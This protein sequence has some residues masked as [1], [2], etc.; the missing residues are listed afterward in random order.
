MNY[1]TIKNC[2]IKAT[3]TPIKIDEKGTTKQTFAFEGV[4]NL[5]KT[6]DELSLSQYA[7]LK[8]AN[9][10]TYYGT[11]QSMVEKAE[12]DQTVQLL[13]DIT[14]DA[15]G[16]EMAT[17]DG[18]P[19]FVHVEGKAITVDLNGKTIA[20]DVDADDVSNFVIGVFSTD[21]GGELTLVDNSAERTGTVELDAAEGK[22]YSLLCNYE[23]GCKITI[24]GGTY[25]ANKVRDCLVYSGGKT[26]A[27]V[28]VNG[29]NF[30]LG[31]V[32]A[33]E[34][35]KPWIFNVL[36]AGDHH[37]LVN[38]GTFNADINRQ[39]WSNEV[40]VA[41][42]CYTVANTD[43]T[44]TVK[45]GAVAYVNEGMLTGPY[46]VR[47]NVGYATL[48]EAF[49]AADDDETVTL[50]KDITLDETLVVA[51]DK[52]S[53]TLD[54]AGKT[55]NAGWNDETAQKHIYAIDNKGNLVIKGNGTINARGIYNYGELTLNGATINAIDANGGYA[56]QSKNGAKF[57]ME[58]GTIATTNEDGDAPGSGYDATT[59]RV[60]E[61]AEFIMNGGEIKNISNYTFAIEN[62]GTTTVKN[63]KVSSIH[64]TLANH[65]TMTIDG[66]EFTC[67]GLEGITAQ[68][69][70]ATDGSTTTINGGTFD[71]KDNY[72]GFNVNASAGAEVIITG[73]NFLKSH[74]GSL[75]G[76]GNIEVSGGFFYEAVPE[77]Y[78]ATDYRSVEVGD[79]RYTVER[80][81]FEIV[82]GEVT[83]FSNDKDIEDVTI[84]YKRT[85]SNVGAWQ[86]LY[87]PFE[88]PVSEFTYFDPSTAKYV[89]INVPSK[90]IKVAKNCRFC[91]SFFIPIF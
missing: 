34:N 1:A 8:G 82:D 36:G 86:T 55:I 45:E 84:T 42:E 33:G 6:V 16:Y 44:Y 22:V 64:S 66:G 67:N 57:T 91:G 17:C 4:N 25:K 2:D 40:Y 80:C 53:I 76:D 69:I 85:F 41:K 61:G 54:L 12:T 65:G 70:W 47:K 43:G 58:A 39:H 15:T 68:V 49:A 50:L 88:I 72:N 31:N 74:S 10:G 60:D 13:S 21:N 3:E 90:N 23:D 78:C 35:G 11:L 48:G 28:T 56:V 75:Y 38:G 77:K 5:R 9:V 52:D 46:F 89:T 87:V 26:D 62:Y 83:E 32:G 24:N 14:L 27:I 73:G 18:Y 51:A 30:T 19:S 71:G 7:V 29:G 63:G 79:G 81:V 59:V 37:V 20:A